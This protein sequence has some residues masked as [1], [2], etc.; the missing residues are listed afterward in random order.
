MN[1]TLNVNGL[2]R[3]LDVWV[4]TNLWNMKGAVSHLLPKLQ[5]KNIC[6][7]TT[8]PQSSLNPSRGSDAKKGK[9]K[10]TNNYG[11]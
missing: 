7:G 4:P 6:C 10:I 2:I 5:K 1:L 11:L 9:L 8:F 3:F